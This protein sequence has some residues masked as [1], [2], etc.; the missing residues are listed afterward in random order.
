MKAAVYAACGAAAFLIACSPKTEA[1]PAGAPKADPAG[2]AAAPAAASVQA[3]PDR[4][5]IEELNAKE[6]TPEPEELDAYFTPD[7][8]KAMRADMAR[9]EVG[10]L[11]YDYRWNAQDFE[12]TSTAYEAVAAGPDRGRVVVSFVSFG[13]SGK[14]TYDMCRRA[15]GQWRIYDVRSNDADDGSLRHQLGLKRGEVTQC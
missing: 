8:A 5:M 3:V 7:M 15:D 11:S 6:T 10:V 4:A 2:A 9:E 1:D 14:T 13:Q 12:I